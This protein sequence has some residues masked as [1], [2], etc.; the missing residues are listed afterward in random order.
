VSQSGC[1]TDAVDQ[2]SPLPRTRPGSDPG[3]GGSRRVRGL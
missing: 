1:G 3:P 2:L